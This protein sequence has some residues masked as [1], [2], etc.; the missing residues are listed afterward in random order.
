M[1]CGMSFAGVVTEYIDLV[2]NLAHN[3]IYHDDVYPWVSKCENH[4]Q[5][6]TLM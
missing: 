6:I 2:L 5:L 4:K 1:D 3:F